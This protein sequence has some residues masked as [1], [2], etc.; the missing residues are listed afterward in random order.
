MGGSGTLVFSLMAWGA[1]IDQDASEQ[2]LSNVGSL[3]FR[4]YPDEDFNTDFVCHNKILF[5][6]SG[7]MGTTL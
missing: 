1:I 3:Y 7:Y 5:F 6:F 4:A 2:R